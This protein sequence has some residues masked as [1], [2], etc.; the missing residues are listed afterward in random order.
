[1]AIAM[2]VGDSVGRLLAI[3]MLITLATGC[4]DPSG[5]ETIEVRLADLPCQMLSPE[6]TWESAPFPPITDDQCLWFSF[7]PNTTYIFEHPLGRIPFDVS[8]FIAFGSDGI[9]ATSGSGNA[10]LIIEADESTVTIRNGQNQRFW[11]RLV[12]E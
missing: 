10:F 3:V 12:L 4:G 6:G 2:R 7:D 5:G 9:G 1:M 11:L 8:G